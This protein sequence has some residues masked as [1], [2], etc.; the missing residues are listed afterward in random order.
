MRAEAV[1]G[2]VSSQ[3]PPRGF[4]KAMGKRVLIVDDSMLM[5]R[6]IAECLTA[7]GWEIAAEATTSQE[8]IQRYRQHRPDAVTLDIVMPEA[9][10]LAALEAILR[11]DPTAKIVIVSALNQTKLIAEAIR[12]GAHDFLVKP[13][14]PEQLLETLATCLA[15]EEAA[16]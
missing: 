1:S 9:T 7:A 12:K 16:V 15:A 4:G 8:A 5:R 6:M 14:M 2:H 10:G 11:E 3:G 13:F